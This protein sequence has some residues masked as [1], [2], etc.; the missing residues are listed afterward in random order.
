MK[1]ASECW[2]GNVPISVPVQTS[3]SAT[4]TTL[5]TGP[6]DKYWGGWKKKLID[7][8]QTGHVVHQIPEIVLLSGC[9]M[10]EI[11]VRHKY[12]PVLCP[13][14]GVTYPPPPLDLLAT[15]FPISFF[16]KT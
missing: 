16:P 14:P 5:Y 13:F 10:V 11:Y 12:L 6:L 3:L 15:I 8:H 1:V 9:P 7:T 4:M 2:G